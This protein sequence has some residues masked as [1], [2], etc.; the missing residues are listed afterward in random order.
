MT[1]R[2]D[3]GGKYGTTATGYGPG[4]SVA[5][6]FCHILQYKV[7]S[8]VVPEPADRLTVDSAIEGAPPIPSLF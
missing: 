1:C 4:A 8:F 7:C 6:T 2:G 3:W 5:T